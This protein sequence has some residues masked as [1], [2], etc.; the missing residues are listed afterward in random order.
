M[1]AVALVALSGILFGGV[2]SLYR[3]RASRAVIGVTLLLALLA[4]AAGIAWMLPR[5]HP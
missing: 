5:G 2:W 1:L 3:Q 4:L